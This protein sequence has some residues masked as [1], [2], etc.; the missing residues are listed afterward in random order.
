MGRAHRQGCIAASDEWTDCCD[1]SA[2]ATRRAFLLSLLATL[3][4][5]C[6]GPTLSGSA[7]RERGL[8]DDAAA[9]HRRAA[10]D[11]H[12]HPGP[13]A[14]SNIFPGASR[15][16]TSALAD[17]RLGRL[18]AA[19][20]SLPA[21]RPVIRRQ[22]P[23]GPPRQFRDPQPGELFHVARSH[24]DK[25]LGEMA[26][27]IA[28][29]P[30]DV[31]AFKRKGAPCA[32]LA[33]E[34]ADALEGDLARVKLFYERGIRVIQLVHYRIN[35]VGDIMTEPAKHGGLTPFGWD[36]VKAMNRAGMIV[37]V[38]HA[39]S[40]TLRGV[41]A[42]SRHPVLDSHTRPT[43]RIETR[44][45][46]SDEELRAVAKTGG[47]IGVWPLARKSRGETFDDFLEDIDHVR[48]V[49]GIDHVG[50]ATDLNGLGP[51][52]VVPTHRE[53]TL[54][55]AG[56]LG[57]GYPEVDVARIIG[58]NFMRVFREVTESRS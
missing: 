24:F 56:L 8:L 17:A 38:A 20:F 33:F 43:V 49:V 12:C 3:T 29:A 14:G 15:E 51:N 50:I 27:T 6:A 18:D 5:A 39:H 19:L 47:V 7:K 30:A 31:A 11:V 36:L 13:F 10:V 54:I 58:G 48:S 22:S 37:D 57:R 32:I 46:R 1:G 35:E 26:G 45:A 9:L 25:V 28:L 4:S 52:T 21:D 55:T 53:F 23:A 40:D 34:G 2:P 42:E 41:V 44:R 16:L